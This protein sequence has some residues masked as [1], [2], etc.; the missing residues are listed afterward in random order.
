MFRNFIYAIFSFLLLVFSV[1]QSS[2]QGKKD[3]VPEVPG[4]K[5]AVKVGA[6]YFGGW[7]FPA[8]QNGHTFHISPTLTTTF[9]DREP[10]WGWREDK[11]GVM[12]EQINYAA[13]NGLSFW[14][15]CWYDNTLVDDAKTMDNLNNALDLFLKAPNK[16]RLDFCLMSCFPVSP[17]NWEKI[18]DRTVPY[19]KEGNYL[20]VEGKPV[21]V[22]F[23]TD[24]VISGM[25]GIANT[26]AALQLYRKKAREAGAG[27]ILIGARTAT[28]PSDPTYQNKYVE[29]GFDFLTTYN[30]ADDGR[31]NAGANDYS[32]LLEGDKKSWNGIS[33]HSA[34]PFVP[35]VGTGY[36]MRP[37]AL[38][39]PNQPA[40]DFW[41]TG[42]TPQK[43]AEQLRAGMQWVKANPK[44]VPGNLLFLYAWNENGEGAWLTPTKSEG[45]A[46]LNAIKQVIQDENK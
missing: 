4:N 29:C 22:F 31:S 36:D 6:W 2:C 24:E 32:R 33:A 16:N 40:S 20:K 12:T 17:V 21:M 15:F 3:P 34:L 10:V 26:K 25:N 18:C 45:A 42:M 38:D 43:I 30:N 5:A 19:F 39:H 41:Y 9:S 1:T 11:A 37:W 23:N 46:R 28:R 13:D 27:E 44:K 8:D 14:G 35:V 7:S